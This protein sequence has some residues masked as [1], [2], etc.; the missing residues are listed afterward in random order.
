MTFLE[1]TLNW[2]KGEIF[3]AGMLAL[4]G[5]ML[6]VMATFFW[7]FGH[8]ATAKALISPFLVVGLFWGIAGGMS[9]YV[10]THRIDT[11]SQEYEKEPRVF[12]DQERKRVDRFIWVY[13][14]ML[15]GWSVMI[16]AG[17]A[18]FMMWG[19]NHGRAIGLGLILFGISGLMVDHTSEQNA[20]AYNAEIN[21]ELQSVGH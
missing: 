8:T 14:Y 15:I 19:G 20:Y 5:A 10:N 2:V 3:E 21:K 11:Y 17:L 18:I 13:P 4:W 12:V 16:L 6:V 9:L 1:H 7:K